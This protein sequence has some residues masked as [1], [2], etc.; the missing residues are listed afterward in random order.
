MDLNSCN[1]SQCEEK[2][3]TP[4]D[5]MSIKD[6]LS[7]SREK[8]NG[9]TKSVNAI[10]HKMY[11]FSLFLDDKKEVKSISS[12]ADQ[13]DDLDEAIFNLEVLVNNLEETTLNNR[14]KN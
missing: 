6:Q 10:G 1:L 8:I 14:R 4:M 12:F 2:T 3:I 9:I 5:D 7:R 11:G 13:V